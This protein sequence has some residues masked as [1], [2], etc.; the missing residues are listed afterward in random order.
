MK[1]E[2]RSLV[3]SVLISIVLIR[4]WIEAVTTTVLKNSSVISSINN[5]QIGYHHYQLGILI[6][7]VSVMADK[8]LPKLRKWII[9][10]FG[11]GLALLL[12]QYTYVLS[13]LGV[14]LPFGYRSKTDYLIVCTS[15]I[16]GLGCLILYKDNAVD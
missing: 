10:L 12:D 1:Y 6:M 2:L 5:N 15:M 16:V 8:F 3:L 7:L 14:N 11:F 9:F 4:F 13:L